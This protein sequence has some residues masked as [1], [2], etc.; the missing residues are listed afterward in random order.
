[1]NEIKNNYKK[2]RFF[3]SG[4]KSISFFITKQK[5]EIQKLIEEIDSS[6]NS[7]LQLSIMSEL[8][9]S[10]LKEIPIKDL[11]EIFVLNSD[12]NFE[13]NSVQ[14]TNLKNSLLNIKKI[15][16]K[17]ES[18]N[19]MYRD[20]VNKIGTGWNLNIS[21]LNQECDLLIKSNDLS[22]IENDILNQLKPIFI[23]NQPKIENNIISSF[24]ELIQPIREVLFES[25]Y[26]KNLSAL[27]INF[28]RL[29]T[30]CNQLH[31][32]H[33]LIQEDRKKCLT[34]TSE[35]LDRLNNTIDSTLKELQSV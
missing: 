31:Q 7:N 14:F 22:T 24:N 6:K 18:N 19:S 23:D 12:G 26:Q 35:N 15:I 17:E 3:V 13:K 11:F 8:K 1:M 9:L 30:D 29:T 16:K 27:F 32:M 10:D 2:K 4:I 28:I 20:E 33:L 5:E 25:K 21:Q 34:L